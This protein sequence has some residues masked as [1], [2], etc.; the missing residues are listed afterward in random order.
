MKE[1][2]LLITFFAIW[3]GCASAGGVM[4]FIFGWLPGSIIAGLLFGRG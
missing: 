1:L 3:V 4:G 2:L